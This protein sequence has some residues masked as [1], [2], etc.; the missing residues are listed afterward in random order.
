MAQMFGLYGLVEQMPKSARK[1]F[2]HL[3]LEGLLAGENADLDAAQAMLDQAKE[4]GLTPTEEAFGRAMIATQRGNATQYSEALIKALDFVELDKWSTLEQQAHRIADRDQLL[5]FYRESLR[6]WPD[7]SYIM[8]RGLNYAYYVGASDDLELWAQELSLGSLKRDPYNQLFLIYLK[9]LYGRDLPLARFHGENLVSKHP[10]EGI[11]YIVLAFAYAQSGD[12]DLA[13]SVLQSFG[14]GGNYES[15][16][17][18]IRICLARLGYEDAAIGLEPPLAREQ[19]IL[20][21][22]TN[23]G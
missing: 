3:E 18:F 19:V 6:R 13:K 22:A 9:A 7:S 5:E 10:R 21:G 15:M 12:E 4:V 20:S 8:A 2:A 23:E 11:F 14:R 16:P 1:D 17:P